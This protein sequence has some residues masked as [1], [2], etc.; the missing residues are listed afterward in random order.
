MNTKAILPLQKPLLLRY[1]KDS[2]PLPMSPQL[3]EKLAILTHNKPLLKEK[4]HIAQ[5][6]VFGSYARGEQT[7]K[8]DIDILVKFSEVTDLVEFEKLREEL[9]K[10]L[11]VK[12][13]LG[14]VLRPSI[15]KDILKQ[16]ILV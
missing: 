2:L 3:K 6:G 12:V 9:E 15:E 1:P 7:P 4:Y 11:G 8:S 10:L 13:D 5:I 14:T 16:T